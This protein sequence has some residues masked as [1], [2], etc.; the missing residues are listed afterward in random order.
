[1]KALTAVFPI[2]YTTYLN[3]NR[4]DENTSASYAKFIPHHCKNMSCK[5]KIPWE[6]D[7]KFP[8]KKVSPTLWLRFEL[9][10]SI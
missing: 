2:M 1:M 4:T 8:M 9:P 3:E 5:D 6:W 10:Y 7:L